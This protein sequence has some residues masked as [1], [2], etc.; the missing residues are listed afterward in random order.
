MGVP[1]TI[2]RFDNSKEFIN[3]CMQS[4]AKQHGI[5]VETTTPHTPQQNG[6]AE[7]CNRTLMEMARTRLNATGVSPKYWPEALRISR[8]QLNRMPDNALAGYISPFK[9]LL[10]EA[11]DI[12]HMQLF[13][14]VCY[15]L[16]L[17]RHQQEAGKLSQVSDKRILV[18]YSQDSKADRILLDTGKVV[19]SR[20]VTFLPTTHQVPEEV[21]TSHSITDFD[22]GGEDY[23]V[24][25][26]S[27]APP[28]PQ[29]ERDV[30]DEL[31]EHD[32]CCHVDDMMIGSTELANVIE[33]KQQLGTMVEIKDLGV[34][35]YY[36]AMEVQQK[37]GSL[38]LTQK[39][40]ILEIL[41]IFKV[42]QFDK[43]YTPLDTRQLSVADGNL[44]DDQDTTKYRE[45]T[46]CLMYVCRGTRPDIAYSVGVL[47]RYMK[48][49]RTLH[50]KAAMDILKY[51]AA[52]KLM[53]IEYGGQRDTFV[54]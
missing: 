9:A 2:M 44:L 47:A 49:P 15:V 41:D 52:T 30:Q 24:P 12:S 7:R 40:Y 5:R 1:T 26:P 14:T 16:R 37:N 35:S 54:G 10:G 43:K 3:H 27:P 48:Q 19:E 38:L 45:M 28:P 6:V 36:L 39:K 33:L 21:S 25:P 20:D 17:P 8:Y 42:P 53:G 18:G 31:D 11:P 22:V 13:A 51:L 23:A 50:L 29:H 32:V 46:G 34:A 4:Y